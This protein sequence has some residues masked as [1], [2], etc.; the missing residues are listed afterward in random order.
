MLLQTVEHR[1]QFLLHG[2]AFRRILFLIAVEFQIDYR[3]QHPGKRGYSA[4]EVL[5][6][7]SPFAIVAEKVVGPHGKGRLLR[8][9]KI[10]RK[11]GID[12]GT[13]LGGLDKGKGNALGSQR[14]P[15]NLPL[16]GGNVRPLDRI[17]GSRGAVEDNR[18]VPHQ[19]DG[20]DAGCKKHDQR[21]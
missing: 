5:G 8:L 14:V 1:L 7:G 21:N 20:S 2:G 6:L 19:A 9:G 12:K 17:P 18:P 15:V 10:V 16:I 3:R 4:Y 13:P 11:I